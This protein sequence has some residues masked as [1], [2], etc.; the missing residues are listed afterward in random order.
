M[1]TKI[2]LFMVLIVLFTIII[3]QNS[4]GIDIQI[5]FW[6]FNPP[7]V[8]VIAVTGFIGILLGF[9]L[10]S[11][12]SGASKKKI[13]EETKLQQNEKENKE[14]IEKPVKKQ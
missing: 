11:I 4:G 14:T 7:K 13:K 1:R 2:I 10:A 3:S 12:Y 9:I 5:L 6:N 8:V